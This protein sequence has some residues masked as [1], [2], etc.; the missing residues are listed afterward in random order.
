MNPYTIFDAYNLIT[1]Y[2][3]QAHQGPEEIQQL[4]RRIDRTNSNLGRKT[5]KELDAA[6]EELKGGLSCMD[7]GEMSPLKLFRKVLHHT[8]T[9][10]FTIT[11]HHTP[12][13]ISSPTRTSSPLTS[14]PV[15]LPC[16]LLTVLP[17]VCGGL[18]HHRRR[19]IQPT[20]QGTV[21]YCTTNPFTPVT[22]HPLNPPLNAP[23][24][25]P[26]NMTPSRHIP[27]RQGTVLC[28]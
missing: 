18:H 22:P 25:Y 14:F 8:F 26:S 20:C 10:S 7:L 27:T 4:A 23:H 13:C 16:P 11:L 28:Y 1:S 19:A 17:A 15:S 9:T 3:S 24:Q 2:I 6:A 21:L 5:T 12:L